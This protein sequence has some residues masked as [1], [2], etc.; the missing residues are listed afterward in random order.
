MDTILQDI[1]FAL[2]SLRR[3]P[4]LVLVATL[5]LALGI[6]VN[7]TLFA[8]VD[9][10]LLRPLPYEDSERLVQVWSTNPSRGWD[11]TSIS[12]A[13][14]RD[15]RD[16]SK[17]IDLAAYRSS[18]FNLSDDDEAP[19]RVSGTRVSPEF[20]TVFKIRPAMGRAFSKEEEQPGKDGVAIISD[21]FW[22]RR[23]DADPG[24]LS[25]VIRLDG[26]MVTIVGV[27]P[28]GFTFPRNTMDIWAPLPQV[29]EARDSRYIQ[30][31]GRLTPGA[32]LTSARSEMDAI[33]SRLAETHP[34]SN[35][36]MGTRII[37]LK[38]EIIDENGRRAAV[39]CLVAVA[40]VLLIACANVA[41]LLLARGASR[42]REL[43]VRAALG[44]GRG[45]LVRQLLT[46]SFI[47]AA[48]GCAIGLLGSLWGIGLFRSIMPNDFP[49]VDALAIDGPVLVY[50]V[51]VSA[52]A[53]VVFGTAPALQVTRDRLSQ[54]LAE[55]GRGGSSGVKHR[56]LRTSFVVGEIA[57]AQVLLISAGLM[58]KG[59]IRMQTTPLGFDKE[60]TLV[61]AV[62]L[63]SREF[64]D[65]TEVMQVQEN[66][67]ARI[68]EI[69]GVEAAGSISAL[70]MSGG[71]GTYYTVEGEPPPPEGERPVLQYRG[72]L[73]GISHAMGLRVV[74]GRDLGDGDRLGAPNVVVIN[75]ALARRHWKDKDPLGQRVTFFGRTWDIV[76]VMADVREFGPDDP[77]P[78]I[79][80][81]PTLQYVMRSPNFLVRTSTDAAQFGAQV[82]AAV[83]AAAPNLPVYDV[84][85]LATH[86]RE[87]QIQTTIMPR[88]LTTFGAM[89]LLLSLIGVYGVMAYNVAQREREL[90]IR[91][92][93]GARMQDISWLVL[94]N[95]L[96]VAALGAGI[97]LLIA[98]G[99]TRTLSTFL[100]GVSA[101]DPAVF[102]GVTIAL[103]AAALAASTVPARRAT[104]VD[105][106]VA[107]RAE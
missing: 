85:T 3:S 34:A 105:P 93:L 10:M 33:G 30:V 5:S 64:P 59:A 71:N 77:A 53:G 32:T 24:I 18:S 68:R 84:R 76:G 40:F 83:A 61:F 107:L 11:Q 20:F 86:V 102:A 80:Y 44:A 19:E 23:F 25:R 29:V 36:G 72:V 41:N 6:A 46:E 1:R 82:R 75:E 27:M 2:R 21:E 99:V 50:A 12:L 106:G 103:V 52:L 78:P 8:A 47:L 81:F 7:V 88:L 87:E 49:R 39:I 54:A 37:T 51:I 42:S 56:R 104:T 69:P 45:R 13:D 58:I 89:A 38:D 74:S 90:G 98:L 62:N 101:F 16:Q 55:G 28:A 9:I 4:G 73:A 26:Q 96:R 66:M 94:G 48:I 97:G 60:N 17:T 43:S 100:L 22:R 91:R 70:P 95:G 67:L 92:V 14:Y 65:T 35:A 63:G 15:W 57:L 31:L 79:A